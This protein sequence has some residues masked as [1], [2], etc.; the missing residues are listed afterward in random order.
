MPVDRF[1]NLLLLGRLHPMDWSACLVPQSGQIS[2][3]LS[4]L[5]SAGAPW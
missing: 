1:K 5:E 4:S 2:V 3:S